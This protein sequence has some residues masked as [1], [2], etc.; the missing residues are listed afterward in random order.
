[1]RI[2]YNPT[3]GQL[4]YVGDASGG[5]GPAVKYSATFNNTTDW[6]LNVT[7]YEFSVTEAVH[8]AGTTPMVQVFEVSGGVA[9]E[10]TTG[11]RFNS[12][13][14][15]TISV[16]ASPDNRFTGRIIIF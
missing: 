3:T 5:G 9:T 12:S 10:V 15:V 13:G 7:D 14:D 8:G 6:T 4:E 11:I 2:I 16:L 1:M